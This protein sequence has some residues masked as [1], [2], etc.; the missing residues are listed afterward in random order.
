MM[1][2][3]VVRR[4]FESWQRG[5]AGALGTIVAVEGSAYQ[6]EGASIFVAPGGTV[7]GLISGGCLESEVADEAGHL[8]LQET[9]LL[10]YDTSDESIFGYG[11]G[12]PGVIDVLLE[13]LPAGDTPLGQFLERFAAGV[14]VA[15]GVRLDLARD[16]ALQD[17]A[18]IPGRGLLGSL[19]SQELDAAFLDK[20]RERLA[21]ARA[22]EGVRLQ[23][24]RGAAE[25]FAWIVPAEAE[26]VIFGATDDAQPLSRIA[27]EIGLK[28]RLIDPRPHLATRERFPAA[29]VQA[30][31]LQ[32]YPGLRDLG[33]HSYVVVMGHQVERD[34]AALTVALKSAV[35][36]I[37]LL[38]SQGRRESMER[39]LRAQ[40]VLGDGEP[41]V[42][43]APAG[44]AIGSRTPEEIALSIVAE[45]CAV[46]R[47]ATR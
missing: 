16:G 33:E 23:D 25:V 39:H 4:A 38:S 47:L 34:V 18:Y 20:V 1:Q 45:S 6:R 44:L 29:E 5:E 8:P 27:Q 17:V 43:H 10:R 2:R 41:A 31:P 26:C 3:E 9:R 7:T 35:P 36:Y 32:E 14:P 28:V 24:L 42:L 46:R 11:M 12:C 37:G 40:G 13:K 21:R 22:P 19:G 30:L 15:R